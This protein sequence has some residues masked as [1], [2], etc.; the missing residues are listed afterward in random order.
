MKRLRFRRPGLPDVRGRQYRA[1]AEI[2][3]TA[4]TLPDDVR[5]VLTSALTQAMGAEKAELSWSVSSG[6]YSRL[7]VSATLVADRPLAAITRLDRALD[8][9]LTATG[10]L[11]EFDVTG[12]VLRVAPADRAWRGLREWP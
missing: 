4:G 10:L 3:Y 9:S 2:T 7:T 6:P 8:E 11:E 12:R 1:E 5:E